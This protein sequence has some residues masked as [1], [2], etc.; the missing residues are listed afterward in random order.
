MMA[1]L[2]YT[3]YL[4]TNCFSICGEGGDTANN[5]YAVGGTNKLGM[6]DTPKDIGDV[7]FMNF[8]GLESWWGGYDERIDNV[9][10]KVITEDDNSTRNFPSD[11]VIT[12][13]PSKLYFGEYIDLLPMDSRGSSTTGFC[14]YMSFN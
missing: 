9:M 3:Y 8:W 2:F 7:S 4:T 10:D 13:S 14:C 5:S 1:M 6:T 12:G 11:I